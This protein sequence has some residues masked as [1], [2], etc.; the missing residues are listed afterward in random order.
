MCI[1]ELG[2]ITEG[3]RLFAGGLDRGNQSCLEP[4]I[5]NIS[6]RIHGK[7]KKIVIN[8]AFE[9]LYIFTDPF[10]SLSPDNFYLMGPVGSL[11]EKTIHDP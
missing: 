6:W 8:G 4:V 2:P 3:Y 10:I 1:P 11:N 9:K 7:C 5:R